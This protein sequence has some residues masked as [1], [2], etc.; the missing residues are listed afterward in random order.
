[1]V[2]GGAVV[3]PGETAVVSGGCVVVSGGFVVVSGELDTVVDIVVTTK[4][5]TKKTI[6]QYWYVQQISCRRTTIS[7]YTFIHRSEK[8]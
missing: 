7:H 8:H 6:L 4:E 2:S 3:A 1:M 5:I